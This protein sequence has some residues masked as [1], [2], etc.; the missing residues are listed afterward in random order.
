MLMEVVMEWGGAM[1]VSARWLIIGLSVNTH[2]H[3]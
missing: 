2:K 3:L 1:V